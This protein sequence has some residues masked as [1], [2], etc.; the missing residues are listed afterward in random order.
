MT[1]DLNQIHF[2]F[3]DDTNPPDGTPSWIAAEDTNISRSVADWFRARM[4][5]LNDGASDQTGIFSLYA[6]INGGAYQPV[7]VSSFGIRAADSSYTPS[8][9]FSDARN[10]MYA[11]IV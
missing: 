8:L 5:I 3:R 9:D 1:V 10:S 2:R 11:P 6:S 7:T 4:A